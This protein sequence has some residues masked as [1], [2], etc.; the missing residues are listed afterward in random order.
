MLQNS[1]KIILEIIRL[2]H[3]ETSLCDIIICICAA[4]YDV[5][6]LHSLNLLMKFF[7]RVIF[8]WS[9]QKNQS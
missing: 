2:Q 9:T 6:K 1:F 3:T 4:F 8:L 7:T 5:N